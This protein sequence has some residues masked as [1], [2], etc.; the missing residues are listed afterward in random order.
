[1]RTLLGLLLVLCIVQSGLCCGKNRKKGLKNPLQPQPAGCTG[2]AV[3]C[4]LGDTVQTTPYAP[5]PDTPGDCSQ[6]KCNLDDSQSCCWQNNQPPSD[7]LNWVSATGAPDPVKLKAN[8]ATEEA[9]SGN[10]FVTASDVAGT[11]SQTAQLYS[12][13]VTCANGDITVK[14]KHWQ[15]KGT[16]LQ[17]CSMKDPTGAPENCQD[18]PATSGSADSVTIPKGENV[19][20]VIQAVGFTEPTGTAAMVDD[21]DVQ[22]EPCAATTA[23]PGSTPAPGPGS[24][25]APAGAPP[26]KEI[27]CDFE[28][29]QPCAYQPATSGGSA[30]K[31]WGTEEAPYQ[32]RLTGVPK[33][34]GNGKKFGA[35]YTKKKGEKT[36]LQSN[37]AFDKEYVVRYQYYKATEGVHFRA[38]CNDEASCPKEDPGNVQTADYR[39]WK[40]ESISCPAGTKSVI[41]ICEN[42]KGESEGACG[43]D[44]IQ[45]LQSTGG[46]PHDASQ[47]AC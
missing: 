6:L 42:K 28:S 17:V 14:V 20:V 33:N 40:T 15:S 9:P 8:F 1:M 25:P 34:S 29:G 5:G 4:L 18:L 37:A 26:C 38:C 41:F 19:R 31:N 35:C 2:G 39:A 11:S 23:A 32:N 3:P 45:L 16:K 10:Y 27:T 22:C 7:Q 12:C 46:D 36:T 24:T 47:S 13:P 30:N 21:V 44:N 43:L